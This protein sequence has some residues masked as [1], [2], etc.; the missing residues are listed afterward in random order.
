[1]ST[2]E[3]TTT[4]DGIKANFDLIVNARRELKRVQ[5]A[6]QTPTYSVEGRLSE[7][8]SIGRGVEACSAAFDSLSNVL[9]TLSC[10]CHVDGAG[11]AVER[12][13]G[14]FKIEESDAVVEE[15]KSIFD[16]DAQRAKAQDDPR[17]E[18]D[19]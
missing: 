3:S 11:K 5:D 1:M 14:F 9:I 4:A 15:G 7:G 16:L 2:A 19:R 12:M 6:L 8:V 17:G 13:N 10:Y 18:A